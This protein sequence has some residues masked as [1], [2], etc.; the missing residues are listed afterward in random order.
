MQTQP[1]YRSEV[2]TVVKLISTSVTPDRIFS[3][4]SESDRCRFR[5]DCSGF[6]G[7]REGCCCCDRRCGARLRFFGIE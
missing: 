3:S 6:C 7:C 2:K 4:S 5:G 1:K